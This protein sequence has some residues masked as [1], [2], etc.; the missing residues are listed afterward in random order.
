[1]DSCRD[2]D[3]VVV[4]VDPGDTTG[5]LLEARG[6]VV[7]RISLP[8]F[9]FDH[10]RN[11]VLKHVPADIDV[12]VSLDLDEVLEPGWRA[13]LESDWTPDTTRLHYK[14]QW[15]ADEERTFHYD[16]IHARHGYEWR[17]ANH[18]A[19]YSLYPHEEKPTQSD[20]RVI[21][22]QDPTKDRSKNLPLLKLAADEE[23]DNPR[24][25]W[26]LGR[27]YLM[28]EDWQNCIVTFRKYMAM[29]STWNAEVAWAC[30]FTANAYHQMGISIEV[31]AWLHMGIRWAP[32]LR[33]PYVE[34]A[35]HYID[36]EEWHLAMYELKQALKIDR[37]I[38][39]FFHDNGAYGEK[40]YL[41]KGWVHRHL[42]EFEEAKVAYHKALRINPQCE[43]AESALDYL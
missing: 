41:K 19:V 39:S 18:E 26:Y 9:R 2:A 7:P 43:E 29:R 35:Q 31:E 8:Q 6:A 1:M 38:H 10:Y 32:D 27:E 15:D 21:Q 20:L 42:G 30:I 40:I 34:L 33:D 12:C 28:E 22:H 3:V 25:M 36:N 24:M 37:D 17:H 23:P 4:G 11:E 16:R 5:E 14:L 13:K